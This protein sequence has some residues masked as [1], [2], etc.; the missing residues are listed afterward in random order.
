MELQSGADGRTGLGGWG[1]GEGGL[2]TKAED[3]GREGV[4]LSEGTEPESAD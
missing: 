2:K 3:G 4:F 1:E